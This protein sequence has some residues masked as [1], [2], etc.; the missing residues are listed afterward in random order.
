VIRPE[1]LGPARLRG[2]P[3]RSFL[4]IGDGFGTSLARVGVIRHPRA[5]KD[6]SDLETTPWSAGDEVAGAGVSFLLLDFFGAN[7]SRSGG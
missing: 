5:Q 3:T 4:A 6:R 1:Q 2:G 7:F